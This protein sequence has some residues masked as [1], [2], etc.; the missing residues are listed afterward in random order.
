M[1]AGIIVD[2]SPDNHICARYG[3]E[4]FAVI[5]PGISHNQAYDTANHIRQAVERTGLSIRR[6]Q[7]RTTVSIGLA[8]YPLHADTARELLKLADKALYR[9]KRQGKNRIETV[10]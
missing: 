10:S 6:K 7:V 4:E 5:L 8:H 9:A 1:I 3:G 2:N